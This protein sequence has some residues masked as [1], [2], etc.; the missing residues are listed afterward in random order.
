M[1]RAGIAVV[2]FF[3]AIMACPSILSAQNESRPVILVYHGPKVGEQDLR[4][5]GE[6]IADIIGSDPRM[7]DEAEIVL[8]GDQNLMNTLLS[9]P[10]VKCLVIAL[11][12]RAPDMG[13]FTESVLWY[14]NQ[15]GGVVGLGNAGMSLPQIFPIYGNRYQSG[16]VVL[17]IDPDTGKRVIK[18]KTTYKKEHD[19]DVSE[20]VPAEFVVNDKRFVIHMNTAVNPPVYEPVE[21]EHGEYKVLYRDSEVGA[22]LVVVYE[23]NGTSIT[24]AGT[25]QMSIKEDDDTYFGNFL[26]DEN[27]GKL[28]RNAVYYAWSRETKYDQAMAGTEEEFAEISQE[29]ERLR[30]WAE[31]SLRNERNAKL[32]RSVLIIAVGVILM[33]I[34]A[35][36][37]FIRPTE[38]EPEKPPKIDRRLLGVIGIAFVLSSV[39]TLFIIGER[40]KED[41]TIMR[42]MFPPELTEAEEDFD[43]VLSMIARK[44][45]EDVT[46]RYSILTRVYNEDLE[47]VDPEKRAGS[48]PR[49]TMGNLRKME[50]L[51]GMVEALNVTI[52]TWNGT[53][54]WRDGTEKREFDMYMY[55]FTDL[56]RATRSDSVVLET[57]TIFGVWMDRDDGSVFYFFEGISDYFY[58]REKT[59]VNLK[60]TQG[61]RYTYYSGAGDVEGAGELNIMESPMFGKVVF[62]GVEKDDRLLIMFSVEGR[63]IPGHPGMLQV[64]RIYR[65]E[66]LETVKANYQTGWVAPVDTG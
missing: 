15:G 5:Y 30:E 34:I 2:G 61:D 33:G 37:A 32:M 41:V 3:I 23:E 66:E 36:F 26:G 20:G 9:F 19:H 62:D 10:Q 11:T 59:M 7:K 35:Y 22:P 12:N 1:T 31:E 14:F 57:P 13:D 17:E 54:I 58:D 28:L 60:I 49:E 43:Y 52:D 25:D 47:Y 56:A 39:I 18:R 65:N 51:Y 38:E 63:S 46:V 44:D 55:D 48:T 29:Q 24:F 8:A 21:P 27:F 40:A 45:M 6:A 42:N 4:A 50:A 53:V 64:I 16:K